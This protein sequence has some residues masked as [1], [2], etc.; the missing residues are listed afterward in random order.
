[1]FEA[2]ENC[3]IH[4]FGKDGPLL[5]LPSPTPNVEFHVLEYCAQH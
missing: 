4:C 2:E 3:K 5:S 1:M